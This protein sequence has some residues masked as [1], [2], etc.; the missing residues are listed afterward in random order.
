METER[1]VIALG[2]YLARGKLQ[3]LQTSVN[4]LYTL[5]PTCNLSCKVMATQV[6]KKIAPCKTSRRN[7]FYFLQRLQDFGKHCK[8]QPDIATCN[9]PPAA[10][11]G[12]LFLTLRDKLQGKLH[13][14]VTL[15][16]K[17]GHFPKNPSCAHRLHT[18]WGSVLTWECKV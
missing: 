17:I 16:G 8:L 3:L 7:R 15:V 14:V 10:C 12:F 13:R 2:F 6:A 4:I 1:K 5:Q 11:N 9:M 18:H